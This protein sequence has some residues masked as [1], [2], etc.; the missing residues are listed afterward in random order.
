MIFILNILFVFVDINIHICLS[1]D[2]LTKTVSEMLTIHH[3]SD[4][5]G[6]NDMTTASPSS[7]VVSN[8][9][10][11][12]DTLNDDDTAF[13]QPRVRKTDLFTFNIKH[14]L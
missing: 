3:R 13:H 11:R 9:L 4:S 10:S 2:R 1:A 12:E 8:G 6:L 14:H 7:S 5:S